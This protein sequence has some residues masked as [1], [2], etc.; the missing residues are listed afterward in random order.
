MKRALPLLL[1][2]GTLLPTV[3]WCQPPA[4]LRWW[5]VPRPV[6]IAFDSAGNIYV[7]E[8]ANKHIDVHA[9]DG[10]RL[11]Q[12][13]ADGPDPWSVSGPGCISVDASDHL[14][15]AEWTTH[16]VDQSGV[17]EFTTGGVF[18][19]MIGTYTPHPSP[20]PATFVSPS[21]IDVGSD[22][23]VYVTDTGNVR[24]QVFANDRTYL[25]QW[26]S[27]GNTIALDDMGHAFEV[28]EG[29]VVRKYDL[30]GVELAHWGS[31]GSG[32]GQFAAPEG[33]AVDAHGNVYVSD[34]YNHRVQV[35]T[36]D[37]TFLMQ[38]GSFGSALGQFYRPMGIAVAADGTIYVSDTW[39]GRVQVF[40]SIA[41]SAKPTSWGQ[42]KARY[43]R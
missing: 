42:I 35:F 14:F 20:A 1:A 31:Y 17:Q 8:F 41:T 29:G 9:P 5:W 18:I 23:R 21:G 30:S 43:R 16:T 26:P 22:G 19:A 27:Q 33:I 36:N 6:G 2:L 7:A 32:P 13:G 34:T 28:E 39:N 40:G 15:I 37:G 12:W 38:W 11:A 10:T 3:A 4:L 24:T 25:Y